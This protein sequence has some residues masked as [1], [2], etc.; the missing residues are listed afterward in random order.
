MGTIAPTRIAGDWADE[1]LFDL[2]IVIVHRF[3]SV[4]FVGRP[5]NLQRKEAAVLGGLLAV[6]LQALSGGG[7]ERLALFLLATMW[8]SAASLS[9]HVKVTTFG[10]PFTETSWNK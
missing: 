4:I 7:G 3:D 2:G 1:R 6:Q 5:V 8:R 9:I 10:P